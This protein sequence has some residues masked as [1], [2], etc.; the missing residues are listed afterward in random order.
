MAYD[1]G[2]TVRLG[3]ASVA[4]DAA[5]FT[6][7][8]GTATDPTAVTLTVVRPDGTALVYGWPAAGGALPLTRESAGRFSADVLLDQSGTWHYRLAGT[9]T[10][11][12]AAEGSLRVQRSRVLAP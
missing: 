1:R 9:G 2:D 4:D 7:L 3:N 8:D 5:A 11:A 10:V 12:A 6:T